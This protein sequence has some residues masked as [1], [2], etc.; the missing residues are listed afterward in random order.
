[1]AYQ[2]HWESG[3]KNLQST[4]GSASCSWEYSGGSCSRNSFVNNSMSVSLLHTN[5]PY[6][7]NSLLAINLAAECQN[8][9]THHT[10]RPARAWL[11]DTSARPPQAQSDHPPCS[12]QSATYAASHTSPQSHS[13]LTI[14]KEI[15]VEY[16]KPAHCEE[17]QA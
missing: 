15:P 11:A 3:V 2:V 9:C 1:M 12:T 4:S 8:A 16:L 14:K 5:S 13:H 7:L 10:L 6:L 17:H